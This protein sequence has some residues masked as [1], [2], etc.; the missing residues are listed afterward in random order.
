MFFEKNSVFFSIK[1]M[2]FSGIGTMP[3]PAG[4]TP[5][6]QIKVNQAKSNL[7]KVNQASQ[8]HFTPAR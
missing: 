3:E 6:P 8:L 4:G 1:G 2:L 7:I 5:A